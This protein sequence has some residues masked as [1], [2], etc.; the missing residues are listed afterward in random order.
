[1]SAMA[2]EE[3]MDWK[4]T[5]SLPA[6][7]DET[8]HAIPRSYVPFEVLEDRIASP[9]LAS[10]PWLSLRQIKSKSGRTY[11]SVKSQSYFWAWGETLTLYMS[12]NKYFSNIDGNKVFLKTGINNFK[13][14]PPHLPQDHLFREVDTHEFLALEAGLPP[15]QLAVLALKH[16]K[17]TFCLSSLASSSLSSKFCHTWRWVLSKSLPEGPT[18]SLVDSTRR[19]WSPFPSPAVG[20]LGEAWPS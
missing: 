16:F 20:L 5:H 12:L 9:A 13:K 19:H 7:I 3:F 1:M 10:H 14:L 17:C 2:G 8:T 4:V 6:P 11:P 15:R 18:S